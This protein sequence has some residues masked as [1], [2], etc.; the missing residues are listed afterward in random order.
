M[1]IVT[2]VGTSGTSI[3]VTVEGA[4][5]S[6]LA[7]SYA[8]QILAAATGADLGIS[9]LANGSNTPQ[10]SSSS[11][12]Q[13]IITTGGAYQLV[14]NFTDIVVGQEVPAGSAETPVSPL[15]ARVTVNAA[16]STAN[17]MSV[18][19]A[20]AAGIEFFAGNQ[21]GTLVSTLGD[22]KFDAAGKTGNWELAF[23]DGNDTVI[24]SNGN[25]TINGG[26]GQNLITL[27]KGTNSV[28]SEGKDTIDGVEGG[29]DSVTLA[30]GN[31]TASLGAHSTVEDKATVGSTINLG[32]D[33]K[34]TGGAGSTVHFDGISG[35]LVG[36]NG[37]TVSAAGDLEV[38]GGNN[39]TLSVS[40]ALRFISA[41]GNTSVTGNHGTLWGAN[42]SDIAVTMSGLALWTANQPGSTGDER[43]D[44][45]KSTGTLEAWTG[46]GYQTIIGTSGSD[47]FVFGTKFEG[48]TGDT[49][50]TITGGSG[51]AN[52]FG[53]L[54]GHTG[55]E[56]TITDFGSAAG[57]L[58]FMYNYKPE[59]AQKAISDILATATVSGGNTTVMLDNNLKVKFLGVTD[60]KPSDFV[61]S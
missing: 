18:L 1:A 24:G 45:S 5:M 26:G 38:Q 56:V 42:A 23:G 19:A 35:T 29:I 31:A 27:G 49:F 20:N 39:L 51:A 2:V 11:K 28:Y 36:A 33:S 21:N 53:V 59:D 54:S 9:D 60:L 40:G 44:A 25:N 6:S 37:D 32:S 52:T 4:Q 13:G 41:T 34:V 15:N 30:S 50:A 10:N 57:N 55:G 47:H 58:F 61:I 17:T 14:G 7:S 22:N 3:Q 48:S 43:I 8:K 12:N 16:G 46:A